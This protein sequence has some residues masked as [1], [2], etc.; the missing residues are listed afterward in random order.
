MTRVV[1]FVTG[2]PANQRNLETMRNAQMSVL[3]TARKFCG[4]YR[5][6]EL[7]WAATVCTKLVFTR[8][9]YVF[10]FCVLEKLWLFSHFIDDVTPGHARLN[11]LAKE[12]APW[13]MP[14]PATSMTKMSINFTYIAHKRINLC[15]T[16]CM[17]QYIF[18]RSKQLCTSMLDILRIRTE[19][20]DCD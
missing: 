11:D 17:L 19:L 8:D 18:W 6:A 13:L 20:C 5:Q 1:K 10:G 15:T 14:L 2:S 9:Y 12:L 3:R 4:N 7:N 16:K